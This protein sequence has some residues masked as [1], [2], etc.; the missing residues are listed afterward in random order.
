[1]KSINIEPNI[2]IPEGKGFFYNPGDWEWTT[3]SYGNQVIPCYIVKLRQLTIDKEFRS[4]P[5]NS[6]MKGILDCLDQLNKHL[7]LFKK[8]GRIT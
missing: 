2:H 3:Y 5:T 4:E 1:M 7:I 8:F 6:Q